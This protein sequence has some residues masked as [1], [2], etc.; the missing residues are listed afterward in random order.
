MLVKNATRNNDKKNTTTN[1]SKPTTTKTK[2]EVDTNRNKSKRWSEIGDG[3]EKRKR[4]SSF[5][6]AVSLKSVEKKQGLQTKQETE[7][8]NNNNNNSSNRFQKFGSRMRFFVAGLVGDE[9]WNRV[10]QIVADIDNTDQELL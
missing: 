4:R 8:S 6:P 9:D 10:C 3:W 2:K 7:T 1:K 5:E